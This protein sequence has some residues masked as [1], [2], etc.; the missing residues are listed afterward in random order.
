MVTSIASVAVRPQS[1]IGAVTANTALFIAG[2]SVRLMSSIA[3]PSKSAKMPSESNTKRMITSEY[4]ATPSSRCSAVTQ[5]VVSAEFP[6]H[7]SSSKLAPCS[8]SLLYQFVPSPK[9]PTVDQVVPASV[10]TSTHIPSQPSSEL[11]INPNSKIGSI[12]NADK[13]K[14][15]EIK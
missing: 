3:N 10:E 11:L 1:E 8:S 4:P 12:T 5:P 6:S 13:S 15:G 7:Q 9:F 2:C 14:Q